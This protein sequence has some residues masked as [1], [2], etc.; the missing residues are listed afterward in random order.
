[1]IRHAFAEG[2]LILRSRGL[3]SPVLALALAIP[4]S[5]A[6]VTVSLRQ[7]LE[8]VIDLS[9]R[10]SVVAVLIHPRLDESQRRSWI[11][12][13]SRSHP[14]WV[15]VAVEPEE[16]AKR[17]ASWFP[18]LDEVL[19]REGPEMLPQMVEITTRDPGRVLELKET[20]EV[21]AVGPTSS[22]NRVVGQVAKRFALVLLLVAGVLISGAVLLA[23]IWVHLELHRNAEEIAIMR[24]MG[25]T[26][27]TVRGPF[28]VAVVV[29]ALLAAALS[30]VLT[31]VV[32]GWMVQLA[33]PLGLAAKGASMVVLSSQILG[34]VG[35]PMLAA[36]ITLERHASSEEN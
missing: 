17:L 22:V 31:V 27:A 5:L 21:L 9:D 30:V 8:P 33:A 14:D 3:I 26:E 15:L 19:Q 28:L 25:A 2:W 16:L 23:A 35:L 36:L 4:I 10:E 24:L 20:A 34:A 29:P 11:S 13:Q 7:W 18:Y 12:D 1:M 32:V 6:G